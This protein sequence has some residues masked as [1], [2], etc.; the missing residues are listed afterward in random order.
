MNLIIEKEPMKDTLTFEGVTAK[1]RGF[2]STMPKHYLI[3]P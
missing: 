3:L 2:L 1:E